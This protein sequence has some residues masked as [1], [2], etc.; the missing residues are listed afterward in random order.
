MLH[1]FFWE[2][3]LNETNYPEEFAKKALDICK[4]EYP[5]PYSIAACD[6]GAAGDHYYSLLLRPIEDKLRVDKTYFIREW[7]DN[8]DD[9]NAQNFGQPSGTWLGRSPHATSG[10]ALCKPVLYKRISDFMLRNDL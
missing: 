6:H 3:I 7:G 10:G 5:Y 2:P 4:E 9:W 8:V 1:S